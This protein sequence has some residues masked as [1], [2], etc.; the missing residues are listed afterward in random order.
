MLS[1]SFTQL[2][3]LSWTPPSSDGSSWYALL[4]DTDR[5]MLI[6]YPLSKRDSQYM[7][8]KWTPLKTRQVTTLM[9]IVP[10]L[11]GLLAWSTDVR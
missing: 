5:L 3:I 7:H 11:C 4:W 2:I 8:F 1:H 6:P 10:A 9:V